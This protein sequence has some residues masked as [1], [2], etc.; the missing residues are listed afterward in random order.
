MKGTQE[1]TV[2]NVTNTQGGSDFSLCWVGMLLLRWLLF[3]WWWFVVGML[4][5]QKMTIYIYTLSN[6]STDCQSLCH[7][8]CW[9][10]GWLWCWVVWWIGWLK[11]RSKTSKSLQN[12]S[13]LRV[14]GFQ[15]F[16]AMIWK[17]VLR[18]VCLDCV[19]AR[20]LDKM[21]GT[22]DVT[23]QNITNTQG[24]SDFR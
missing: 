7:S 18:C 15:P 22:Q 10:Q 23:V 2:Q 12:I 5:G 21:Q 24:G 6:L 14:G 4:F 16:V 8:L 11:M 13:K 17:V 1:I 20:C 9:Q 19:L 3:W